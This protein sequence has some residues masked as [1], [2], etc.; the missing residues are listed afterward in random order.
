MKLNT[1]GRLLRIAA[2]GVVSVGMGFVTSNAR[3]D[4]WDKKTIL[5]VNEPI[6]V[7]DTVLQPG[8]YVFK[9]LNS[10]SDRH[11]VQ[12]FN[13]NQTRI[14]DTQIAI[15]NYRLQPTDN[16]RFGFWETP[17]G[18]PRALRAWF[19]PGDNFGQ[20]FPYPK[21][22]A[23]AKPASASVTYRE[24]QPEPAARV[25]TAVEVPAPVAE[26]ETVAAV[27]APA[28][29]PAPVAAD[30]PV[31]GSA[32]PQQDAAADAGRARI[33]PKTASSYPL[34]GLAG[35]LSL[36]GFALLRRKSPV[37]N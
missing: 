32:E 33:L 35:L 6:Q 17:A 12:I 20:E 19:Y 10:Q 7:R 5:T 30:A 11:I 24:A 34:F 8:Q 25:E 27:E 1:S 37:G 4:Q 14:I 21:H 3:A 13:Y 18:S 16:S 9:L 2:F 29:E 28:P 31:Q 26:P 23:M 22:L 36:G 15:P